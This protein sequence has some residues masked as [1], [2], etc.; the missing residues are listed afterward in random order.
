[1]TYSELLSL[2]LDRLKA[3]EIEEYESD[4][5]LLFQYLLDADRSF[6][7]MHGMDE[8]TNEQEEAILKAIEIR[9][10][11]VPLQHITGYQNFMGLEF[12]VSKDCL[13]PRFDTEC[14]VEEAMLVCNDGDKVLD[15]CTGSGCIL[16]SLMKYKNNLTGYGLDISDAALNIAR[17]NAKLLGNCEEV[18]F[19]D[20]LL[21]EPVFIQSDLFENITETDFDIIVSNPPYI[22]SDVIPGLM[23]EVKDHDPRLALDGGED[24]LVFYRKIVDDARNYLKKG[25]HLLV[26]IGNDQGD[27]VK[28]LFLTNGYKEVR[29]V[30]DLSDNDRVVAGHL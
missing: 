6:M 22:R 10:K 24:G 21:K 4:S 15:V 5:R 29:V 18:F 23:P 17:E 7:F 12:K 28:D 9:Q 2:C 13:I 26:E 1:M 3:A 19:T 11:R 25:G 14:L 20:A 30:K 27:S 8:V 16:I